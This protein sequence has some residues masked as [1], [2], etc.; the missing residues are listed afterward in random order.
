MVYCSHAN[1]WPSFD[2]LYW[3]ALIMGWRFDTVVS[4]YLLLIPAILMVVGEMVRI[5]K[6]RYY[7]IIHGLLLTGYVIAFFAC[8]VDIPFFSYFFNRLNAVSINEIESF[9]LILDMIL[10]EPVYLFGFIAFVVFAVGYVFL[11]RW[12]YRRTLGKHL[13]EHLP[14]GWAIPMSV[15]LLFA[16]FI[17]MRG[18]LSKKSPIRVGTAY[19]CNNGFLNQLGLN[20]VFTFV[21]SAEEISKVSN[22][23]ISLSTPEK[24]REV[25]ESEHALT[26]D[27]TM[28]QDGISIALPQ[29]TNVIMVLME[30]MTIDKTGLFY[31]EHSLTSNLDSL[32][33]LGLTFTEC[34]SAGIHTYNGLYSTLY[35]HPALLSRHTM[36]H[37]QLPIMCGLPQQLHNEGYQTAFFMTHDE[38]YDNMRGFL[39]ANGFD[40]VVGQSHFPA[41]ETVGTWGVP[42]HVLFDHVVEHCNAAVDTGPFF[43]TIMTCSDHTPY[44]IP[45]DIAMDF[46]NKDLSQRIVEYTDWSIG[47]FMQKATQQTWFENTIFVFVADH[48]AAK[49]FAYDVSLPYHHIPLLFY[50]PKY[51]TPCRTDRLALQLDVAPTLM[52]MFPY[53]VEN[54]AFGLDLMRQQR[55]YA[56][57][58]S[59]DKISVLDG[60][61]LY[62]YRVSA[63][64]ES[65]YHYSDTMPDDLIEQQ[66][67]RAQ[68][69]R[70]YAFGMIQQSYQMLSTGNCGCTNHLSHQRINQ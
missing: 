23:P 16:V 59:D 10:S 69:M 39:L 45:E 68:S 3:Y 70:D 67:E 29:G 27:S 41:E 53:K 44:I 49:P 63:G 17:G 14:L 18:R 9:S 43:V 61:Y 55:R 28:I 56:Y 48:G 20:P 33:A 31:P 65:V 66:R 38:D 36:K 2:G 50:T 47:H 24:A 42:D 11:M 58:S 21:K 5:T 35:S 52:G 15:L 1:P 32:M 46:K 6:K 34:Y 40:K 7:W 54:Q 37:T 51:I 25:Y 26:K 57:F 19:F 62:L 13:N 12:V 64:K 30:S 4:C 8:A 22:R 60:E